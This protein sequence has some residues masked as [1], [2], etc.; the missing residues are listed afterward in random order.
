[1]QW[2][3]IFFAIAEL[4]A[5]GANRLPYRGENYLHDCIVYHF[6]FTVYNINLPLTSVYANVKCRTRDNTSPYSAFWREIFHMTTGIL[7][8]KT[9][10]L[11]EKQKHFFFYR[12]GSVLLSTNLSLTPSC[13]H[14]G[15]MFFDK[16][17]IISS[18]RAFVGPC[19]Y[20][21]L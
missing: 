20:L 12:C 2:V 14:V 21:L 19:R 5:C 7:K 17:L 6:C 18:G 9:A 10:N 15:H 1:M 4:P 13:W 3:T 8:M 16:F 11:A